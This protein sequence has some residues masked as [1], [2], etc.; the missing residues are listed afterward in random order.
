METPQPM[1]PTL[2]RNNLYALL[3]P[4]SG[5]LAFVGNCIN[6][7]FAVIPGLPFLCGTF[8]GVFSL[9]ALITGIVGLVQLKHTPQKGRG[10]AITGILLG[11]LGLIASC[12]IPLIG[13][14]ILA[15]LGWRIGD[16]LLVPTG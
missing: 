5:V 8:N 15:A 16:T 9:G 1:P 11:T 12:L 6:L 14:A 4:I 7:V 13:T 3:S 2:I 10:L